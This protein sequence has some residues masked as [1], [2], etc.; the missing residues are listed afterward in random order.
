MSGWR[1]LRVWLRRLFYVLVI[2]VLWPLV[3]T[4]VYLGVPPPASNI[5]L[6]R[7]IHGNGITYDWV[8]L[9]EIS[10]QL[11]RAVITAEDARFCSHNGV[12]WIEVQEVI[13]DVLD[14]DEAPLRGASTIPMQAAKNLFLWDGR[15]TIRKL[16]EIPLAYWMDLVWTQEADDRDLSQ[17]RR[18][19]AGRLWRGVCRPISFQE[20]SREAHAPGGRLAG[21]RAAQSDQAQ[22]RQALEKG[23]ADRPAHHGADERNGAA[24]D[25]S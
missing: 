17:H 1:R 8:S 15:F 4:I 6:L 2:A 5:M 11:P 16:L 20:A 14:D 23:A 22:C 18:M 9:D 25:L 21:G 12:D 3:M 13:D 7:L 24:S 19:G 10:P